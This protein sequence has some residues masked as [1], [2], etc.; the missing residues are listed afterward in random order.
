[1]GLACC[2]CVNVWLLQGLR[3]LLLLQLQG[4]RLRLL[5]Q[6]LRLLLLPKLCH[7]C[8]R[9]RRQ[10]QNWLLVLLL[11]LLAAVGW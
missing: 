10:L 2:G 1:M 11:L 9:Q 4:L 5:C 3:L 6:V 7:F 8:L